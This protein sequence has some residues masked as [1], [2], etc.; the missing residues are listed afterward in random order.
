MLP[1]LVVAGR[2]E[3]AAQAIRKGWNAYI[4]AIESG[5]PQV[6]TLIVSLY[7]VMLMQQGRLQEGLEALELFFSQDIDPQS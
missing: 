1:E 6:P 7:P 5:E 3:E 4:S 2:N